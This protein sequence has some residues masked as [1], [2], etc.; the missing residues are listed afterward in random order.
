MATVQELDA[1]IAALQEQAANDDSRYGG[2]RIRKQI[3]AL[4]AQR[5]NLTASDAELNAKVAAIRQEASMDDSKG[6]NALLKSAA[7]LIAEQK[8]REATAT[9]ANPAATPAQIWAA[10]QVV[11]PSTVGAT[12]QISDDQPE[13]I[14]PADAD[15]LALADAH[16]YQNTPQWQAVVNAY[17]TG[18]QVPDEFVP[19]LN[20]LNSYYTDGAAAPGNLAPTTAGEALRQWGIDAQPGGFEKFMNTAIPIAT[21][22]IPGINIVSAGAIA[23]ATSAGLQGGSL[24]DIIKGGVTGGALAYGGQQL[25]GAA[26]STG[27]ATTG[28]AEAALVNA[29]Y[30]NAQIATIAANT[31][32]EVMA[33]LASNVTP[34]TGGAFVGTN[35]VSMITG[36]GNVVVDGALNSAMSSITK[37]AAVNVLTGNDPFA[38]AGNAALGGAAFGGVSAA[39]PDNLNITGNALVDSSLSGTVNSA[40]PAGAA[41]L[42]TGGDVGNALVGGG[43]IGAGKP[44]VTAGVNLIA[45][46][47][48]VPR[49]NSALTSTA[50]GALVGGV[51]SGV[52]GGDITSG[53]VV[54]GLGGLG[55]NL[56]GQAVDYL[57][58]GSMGTGTFG[59][60]LAQ[61]AGTVAGQVIGNDLAP[62]NTPLP[63][64]SPVYTNFV[65]PGTM[66]TVDS[67]LNPNYSGG[68]I[69]NYQ[70]LAVQ[71]ANQARI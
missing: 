37:N 41:A 50:K 52:G 43:L 5:Y 47:N 11:S 51:S 67:M 30:T 55:G 53:M 17:N 66:S 46:E 26:G 57:S 40:L 62:S 49:I 42:A 21:M 54:G 69:N 64:A 18:Q 33:T 45:P 59:N 29:G 36:S 65:Q 3:A 19:L 22:F 60:T 23:G 39:I 14:N 16:A 28:T 7:P 15:K 58:N 20:R 32:P 48:E 8:R 13:L 12:R 31:T 38:N 10:R 25:F 27:T 2:T 70:S 4:N 34:M 56:A 1:Q 68:L 9:L 71:R 44:L 61:T 35:G 6:G 24:G 63:A